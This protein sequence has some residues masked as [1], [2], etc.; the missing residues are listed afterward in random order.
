MGLTKSRSFLALWLLLL[1]L[2]SALALTPNGTLNL[3]KYS[4][5]P[6]A[7]LNLGGATKF[8]EN[9]GYI[10]GDTLYVYG[11]ESEP[12]TGTYH[13]YLTN[14]TSPLNM[15]QPQ[16]TIEISQFATW[17][18]MPYAPAY[19]DGNPV[20]FGGQ[21]PLYLIDNNLLLRHYQ[22]V[23]KVN[24]TNSC[25]GGINV[26]VSS[27]QFLNPAA[28]YHDGYIDILI[29]DWSTPLDIYWW[30]STDGYTGC[31]FTSK[32]LLLHAA[33]TPYGVYYHGLY[34]IAY[35]NV[36]NPTQSTLDAATGRSLSN[37]TRL[38][39]MLSHAQMP[40]SWETTTF[41]DANMYIVPLQSKNTFPYDFFADYNAQAGS[42]VAFDTDN[43]TFAQAFN[44]PIPESP[45][46][47]EP[48]ACESLTGVLQN[49]FGIIGLGFITILISIIAANYGR[50]AA[51][52]IIIFLTTV[53]LL[54]AVIPILRACA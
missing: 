17:Q 16:N 20:V 11:V 5:N 36:T 40:Q 25:S 39:T 4:G 50:S 8:S 48:T 44:A 32:G 51:N 26:T 1:L 47:Q 22:T 7:T 18:G 46:S 28:I 52:R 42:G 41:T 34:V 49:S 27:G 6:V 43:R 53:F 29:S 24:F 30:E 38:G 35:T 33:D 45:E 19:A 3:T 14:T 13:L 37:L 10:E 9:S 31:N 15:S 21:Y 12:G 23:N 2:P 54:A